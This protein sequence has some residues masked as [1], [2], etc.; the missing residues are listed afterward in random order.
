MTPT[1]KRNYKVLIYFTLLF[2]FSQTNAQKQNLKEKTLERFGFKE[3]S[4]P[5]ENDTI[6]YYVHQKK[7]SKPDKVVIYLQGTT[8]IPL[9]FFEI[10]KT[11]KG[12]KYFQ[13]FSSDYNLLNESYLY[14]IISL[15]GTPAVK[16]Y[17]TLN[18]EKYNSLNALDYRVF[19]ADI[20]INHITKHILK[21]KKLIVYGHSEGAFVAPKLATTNN[22]ITHLGV[23]GGSAL[24]DFFDFILFERKSNLR[25]EQSDSITQLNIDKT[26]NLFKTVAKDSLNTSPSNENEIT[27]YTNKRWWS[28]AEPTINHLI[29]IDIPIYIQ[30]GTEDESSPIETNYLIPLEF[31]RLGKNN[32]SFNVCIGCD[33]GFVNVKTGKDNWPAIFKEF[34]EWTEK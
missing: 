24:P 15:P 26:I 33:H 16:G 18:L 32:L 28:Y 6:Y 5:V 3:H 17:G 25:G 23:W 29:K 30:L 34:I 19:A 1:L 9:P 27:E 11:E 14:V 7:N 2:T 8:P 22:K 20:V 13:Y 31:A 12:N 10:E 21:P 4:I